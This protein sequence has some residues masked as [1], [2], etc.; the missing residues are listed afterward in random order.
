MVGLRAVDAPTKTGN[1]LVLVHICTE[2]SVSVAELLDRSQSVAA[3]ELQI[4]WS[5]S[6][7]VEV[8]RRLG[9]ALSM[10]TAVHPPSAAP[11]TKSRGVRPQEGV[12]HE[13]LLLLK[14][15]RRAPAAPQLRRPAGLA[16]SEGRA[17]DV[18]ARFCT[19]SSTSVGASFQY[20]SVTSKLM[21]ETSGGSFDSTAASRG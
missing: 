3:S 12:R 17:M 9:T 4:E 15:V 6:S 8:L 16:L 20:R 7:T 2:S 1:W 14:L 13:S 10:C 19:A 11:P 18:R 5:H 21:E